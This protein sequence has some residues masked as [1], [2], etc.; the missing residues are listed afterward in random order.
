MKTLNEI[1]D[2]VVD[3]LEA[4]KAIDIRVLDVTGLTTFTDIIIIASGNTD[5][6]VRALANKVVESAKSSNLKPLGT[7]GREEGDWALI[8][9]G[10]VVVNIMRPE[11]RDYYQ[12]EKLWSAESDRR[13]TS[14]QP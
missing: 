8:D 9:L 3:E 5:R 12:L 14:L 7:E 6:Q 2:L 1:R 11:T 4:L 10:D 13:N